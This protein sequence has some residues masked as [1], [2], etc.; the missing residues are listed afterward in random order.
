MIRILTDF[1]GYPGG[2]KRAFAAGAR[3]KDLDA[4]YEALLVTKGLAERVENSPAEGAQHVGR[5]KSAP[6]PKP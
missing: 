1:T 5:A 2:V 4:T 3:P 6:S